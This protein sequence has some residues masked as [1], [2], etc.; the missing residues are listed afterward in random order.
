MNAELFLQKYRILEDLLEKRY[1]GE[2][3]GS[4]SVVIEYLHSVDSREIRTDL[5]TMRE[6]RNLLTHNSDEFG[7]PIAEPSDRTLARM[8][9]II[10]YVRKP[11]LAIQVG[12]P[13]DQIMCTEINERAID[14]MRAMRNRGYS[15]IPVLDHG[16]FVGIFSVKA[17]FNYLAENGLDGLHEDSRIRDLGDMLNVEQRDSES[18]CF[19]PADA[20]IN[21]VREVFRKTSRQNKKL[22]MVLITQNGEKSSALLRV[23]TPWDVLDDR[24]IAQ[25]E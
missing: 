23:L 4:S 3:I 10:E 9:E 25:K 8:D 24:I 22:A 7:Y 5:D 1:A 21:E 20:T 16:V 14:V 18:Y 12:T 19:M 13:A 15:H 17:L 11:R 2:R 6:L